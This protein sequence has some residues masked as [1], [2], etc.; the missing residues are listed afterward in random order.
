MAWID[1]K[2]WRGSHHPPMAFIIHVVFPCILL[3]VSNQ[4]RFPYFRTYSKTS[5]RY[6]M[7]D[8]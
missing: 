4:N 1:V 2:E 7:I 3:F 5:S 8:S 6:P